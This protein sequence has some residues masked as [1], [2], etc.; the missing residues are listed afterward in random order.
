MNLAGSFPHQ[1]KRCQWIGSGTEANV[2]TWEHQPT[3]SIIAVKIYK[4][5]KKVFPRE[6]E[7][8]KSLPHH[9]SVI[10]ILAYLP[11][12]STLHGDAAIF[13]Y[14]PFRDLFELAQ[15]LWQ[16]TQ[17]TFSEACVWSIFSQLSAGIAFIHEGVGW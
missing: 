7:I 14:C 3:G 2:E 5:P 16:K 4:K 12:S 9:N 13:E 11:N 10:S 15:D 17:G 6:I 8:L 1:H